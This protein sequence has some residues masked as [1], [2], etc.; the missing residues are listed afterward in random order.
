MKGSLEM[1]W[2]HK[3]GCGQRRFFSF[4]ALLKLGNIKACFCADGN[5]PLERT[6]DAG[7]R[8]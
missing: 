1:K 3:G 6:D 8:D 7:K 2:Y 5:E 4:C